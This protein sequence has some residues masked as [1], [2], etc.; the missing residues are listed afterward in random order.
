M[1]TVYLASAGSSANFIF[2][3]PAAIGSGN[4]G[5]IKKMDSNP[6]AIAIT[7]NGSDTIDG[8]NAAVLVTIQ[9]DAV[10]IVDA[11]TGVWVTV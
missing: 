5:I 3:L 7:P 6:Y 1:A 8:V 4:I 10:R 2:N 9:Y 11:E